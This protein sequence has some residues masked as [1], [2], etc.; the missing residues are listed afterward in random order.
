[1]NKVVQI[2]RGR[3][4]SDDV[5]AR[6]SERI[7]EKAFLSGAR[8]PEEAFLVAGA[9]L[10]LV[11]PQFVLSVYGGR[12]ALVACAGSGLAGVAWGVAAYCRSSYR[13]TS[14]VDAGTM[15]Q[16]PPSKDAALPKAA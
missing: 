2:N 3:H 13:I 1:M 9:F 11:L 6:S 14:C 16:S 8:T 15:P 7:P 5:E 12:A 4:P 10:A